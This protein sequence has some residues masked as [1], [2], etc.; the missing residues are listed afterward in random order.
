MKQFKITT[1]HLNQT[2]DDD[3]YLSPDDP[4]NELRA[5]QY[6]AGLGGQQRLSEYNKQQEGNISTTAA[7]NAR[8]MKE[9]NI[10]PG[11]PEWFNLWFSLPYLTGEKKQ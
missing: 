5:M 3:C 7:E 1:Q 9:Q 11:T 6:L 4:I 10:K 8:I 2:S